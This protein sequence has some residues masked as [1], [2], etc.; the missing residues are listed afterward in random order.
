[1]AEASFRALIDG[2]GESIRPGQ[3]Q[4]FGRRTWPGALRSDRMMNRRTAG[5]NHLEGQLLARAQLFAGVLLVIEA[6]Y[7]VGATLVVT[8]YGAGMAEFDG[9]PVQVPQDILLPIAL[10]VAFALS[11][12]WSGRVLLRARAGHQPNRGAL[13]AM[14]I[15]AMTNLVLTTRFVL[16][17][18]DWDPA[19]VA[20]VGGGWI[21]V[22]SIG[23]VVI[24]TAARSLRTTKAPK[25][26]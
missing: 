18:T 11:L 19:K 10:G 9:I 13:F 6:L 21:A 24:V 8:A 17:P 25:V 16:Y 3:Y 1:M 7:I 12:V 4:V 14:M 5:T 23:I 15:V 22:V 20:F 26:I 2:R